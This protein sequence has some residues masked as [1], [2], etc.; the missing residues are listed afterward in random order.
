MRAEEGPAEILVDEQQKFETLS[1][2][3]ILDKIDLV[4]DPIDSAYDSWQYKPLQR[5][6]PKPLRSY[7]DTSNALTAQLHDQGNKHLV[8]VQD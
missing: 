5:A 2:Q 3:G 6:D 7:I 4:E 8:T 1:D